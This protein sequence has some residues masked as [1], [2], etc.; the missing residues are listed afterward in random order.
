M[1]ILARQRA[2]LEARCKSASAQLGLE[3]S[4][5]SRASH[6]LPQWSD[7]VRRVPN[8]A[9]RSAL[10]GAISKGRRPYLERAEIHAQGGNSVIYTGV[11]LDQGDLDVWET[12]LH[13]ARAQALGAECRVTAYRL[14]KVLGRTDTGKNRQILDK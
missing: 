14:L 2:L 4:P 1:P 5:D 9:L 13:M 3:L 8:I 10:F 12:V 11:L 7:S 6:R